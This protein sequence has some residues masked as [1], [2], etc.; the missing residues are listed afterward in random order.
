MKK[1]AKPILEGFKRS[2]TT[3]VWKR[4]LDLMVQCVNLCKWKKIE[5]KVRR[6]HDKVHYLATAE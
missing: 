1:T 3:L 4:D 2:Q 6:T 5:K